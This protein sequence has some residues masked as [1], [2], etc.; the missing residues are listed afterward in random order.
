LSFHYCIHYIDSIDYYSKSFNLPRINNPSR[1][2]YQPMFKK[3]KSTQLAFPVIS[4][5]DTTQ[6]PSPVSKLVQKVTGYNPNYYENT[7][8]E[9]G[10]VIQGE[11]ERAQQQQRPIH[12]QQGYSSIQ[13]IFN[14]KAYNKQLEREFRNNQIA[15]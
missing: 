10:N 3:G 1:W 5:V 11:I 2:G 4:D 13:D 6:Y 7:F 9:E 14:R 8:D 12:F 15:P